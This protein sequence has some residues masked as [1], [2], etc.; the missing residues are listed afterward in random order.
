MSGTINV[1]TSP[2]PEP[3]AWALMALGFGAIG[4]TMRIRRR[5]TALLQIA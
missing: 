2:V 4:F 3:G 5:R 1:L